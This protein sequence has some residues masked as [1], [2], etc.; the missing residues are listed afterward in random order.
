MNIRVDKTYS[1]CEGCKQVRNTEKTKSKDVQKTNKIE[2]F[3]KVEIARRNIKEDNKAF[4][5]NL[6][7]KLLTELD[8]RMPDKKKI[9]EIRKAISEGTYQCHPGRIAEKMLG[10]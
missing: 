3:D 6:Q 5:K 4:V 7:R 10:L 9:E 1:F 8:E 2:K